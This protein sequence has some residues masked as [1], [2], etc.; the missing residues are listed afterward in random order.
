LVMAIAN[1]LSKEARGLDGLVRPSYVRTPSG[2]AVGSRG[3]PRLV[4]QALVIRALLDA[5]DAISASIYRHEAQDIF[6]AT[7]VS[8]FKPELAF[9]ADQ[10]GSTKAPN[11]EGLVAMLVAGEA[12]R[13]HLSPQRQIQWSKLSKPWVGALRDAA[14]RLP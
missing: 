3:E 13:P 11:L 10:P 12:L 2:A 5:A 7:K 14:E 4:D 8:F 6:A 1:F 9:Y